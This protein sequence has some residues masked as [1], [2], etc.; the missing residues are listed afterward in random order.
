MYLSVDIG[1]TKTLIALFSRRG[2]V[3][4]K[5]KFRTAKGAEKFRTDLARNLSDFKRFQRIRVI[6]VAIPG[7]VQKNYSVRFGNRDWDN[8]DLITPIKNLF[9]CPIYFENDANLA[10]LYEA[11]GLPGRTVFLTFR[12]GLAAG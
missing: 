8:I 9:N 6:T 4:K 7:V 2:R 5:R 3:L 1:G 11:A 12:L 10:T